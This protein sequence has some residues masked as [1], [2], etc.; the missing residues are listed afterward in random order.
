MKRDGTHEMEL[1][2]TTWADG[3]VVWSLTCQDCTRTFPPLKGRY[4]HD[5]QVT[6]MKAHQRNT[7]I[8]REIELRNGR[9]G[10]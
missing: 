9:M 5:S 3:T 7:Q 8:A 10:R 2:S 1:K 4:G 6:D